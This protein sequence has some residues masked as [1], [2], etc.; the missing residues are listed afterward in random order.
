MRWISRQ[1]RTVRDAVSVLLFEVM[2]RLFPDNDA[3]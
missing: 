1:A 3:E 2:A